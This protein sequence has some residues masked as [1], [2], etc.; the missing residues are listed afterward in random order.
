MSHKKF[1]TPQKQTLA[2]V[3]APASNRGKREGYIRKIVPKTV[4]RVRNDINSW[5]AALKAA[6]NVDNHRRAKLIDLYNDIMLDAHLSSQIELRTLHTL[7]AP[8]SLTKGGKEK[9]EAVADLLTQPW[10]AKLNRHLLNSIFYGHS[11][12]EFSI[13]DFNGQLEVDLLPRD[14][15]V[16][17]SGFV[18][19]DRTSDKGVFYRQ[20][21]E[22]GTWLLEFG[23]HNDYGIINMAVPHILFKRFA[24]ACWSELCEIYGIPPRFIKTDTQDPEMLDRAEAMLRDMGSAAYFIIDRD[25]EF[26][27]AKGADTNGDVYANLISLCKEEVS[28]LISG[29]VL[30]QD[31]RNGNRSKEESSM[32]LLDKI[33]QADRVFV[34]NSW[35]NTIIP[36]LVKIG[37][38]TDGYRFAF[39]QEE[40]IEKLWGMTKEAM[41][42]MEIDPKWVKDKFGINVLGLKKDGQQQLSAVFDNDFFD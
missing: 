26:Q 10:V 30:G 15:V 21:R 37:L 13:N 32:K 27:F 20:M 14:H 42:Y 17:E 28:L 38:I 33:V 3:G 31:T 16:P 34:E 4:S 39:Q 19:Y 23:R 5:K 36:A 1:H 9:D 24:Q 11:L 25:E 6:D 29:A 41:P 8:F 12:V 7:S 18:L 35:N 40:D 2:V 22:Y